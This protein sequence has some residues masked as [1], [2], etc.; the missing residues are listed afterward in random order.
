MKTKIVTLKELSED[1]PTLCL[2]PLRVFEECHKCDQFKQE[3]R[4][5]QSV[6]EAINS[7]KC[8]PRIRS[9]I[10]KLL[11][12]KKELLKELAKINSQLEP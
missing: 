6:D 5:H 10:R 3:F 1:N 2:S 12:R 8:N 4:K 11:E 9:D 7:M